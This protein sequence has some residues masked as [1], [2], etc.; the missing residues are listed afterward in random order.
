MTAIDAG[1]ARRS[2][3]KLERWKRIALGTLKLFFDP[4]TAPRCAG[5]AFFGFLSLFPAIATVLLIYGL[6][7]DTTLLVDTIVS[8]EYL[9]PK[10]ALDLLGEQLVMLANQ[11]STTLG[12]GLLISVPLALW[13]G[14][15]GVDA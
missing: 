11:S 6:V 4:D 13:S 15:R 14:S 1:T 10:M 9:L 3:T 5:T 8:L 7:A 12:I 2:D